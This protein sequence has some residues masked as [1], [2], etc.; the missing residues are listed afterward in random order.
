[1]TVEDVEG[2][3]EEDLDVVE[4]VTL[5]SPSKL[6]LNSGYLIDQISGL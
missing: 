6:S 5:I 3:I 2:E 4:E 1:V